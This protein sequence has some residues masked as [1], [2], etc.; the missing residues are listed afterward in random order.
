MK[1]ENKYT[2]ISSKSDSNKKKGFMERHYM[3]GYVASGLLLITNFVF[4]GFLLYFRNLA[5][6]NESAQHA[7]QPVTE[8][9]MIPITEAVDGVIGG[10][11]Q[12]IGE[13]DHSV[14]PY[15]KGI[16]LFSE[17]PTKTLKILKNFRTYQQTNEMSCGPACAIM[18]MSYLGVENISEDKLVE[19]ANTGIEGKPNKDGRY[20]TSN[21]DL[22]AAIRL[23]GLD[24]ESN[25]GNTSNP[26]GNMKGFKNFIIE[27]IENDQPILIMYVDQGGHWQVIIG[28]DDMGTESTLDDVVILADPYDTFDHRQD[29]YIVHSAEKLYALFGTEFDYPI[30][31]E[32]KWSYIRVSKK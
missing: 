2:P 3:A 31:G 1:S 11:A 12:Y 23:Y 22:S 14:T 5:R 28:Y 26:F 4:L 21:K 25:S 6:Y 27:S 19:Q 13:I 17:Q 9:S 8:E 15:F 29:G 18:V 7:V 16:D 24:V 20:G 10:A 32:E 30:P